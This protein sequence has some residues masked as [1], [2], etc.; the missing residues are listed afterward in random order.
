MVGCGMEI[1]LFEGVKNLANV[2]KTPMLKHW[3]SFR[4]EVVVRRLPHVLTRIDR[5]HEMVGVFRLICLLVVSEY[6]LDET[7]GLK[8]LD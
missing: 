3:R 1:A 2:F 8:A 4:M 6:T 7:R 5:I